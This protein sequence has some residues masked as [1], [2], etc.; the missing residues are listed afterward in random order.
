MSWQTWA[1]S[2]GVS[3]VVVA[4]CGSDDGKVRA[5][6]EDGGAA[7]EAEPASS[8]GAEAMASGGE[9]ASPGGAGEAAAEGGVA[10]GPAGEPE[11]GAAGEPEPGG[12]G[13]A[14]GAASDCVSPSE[15]GGHVYYS[16]LPT[17]AVAAEIR[18]I[19]S[20]GDQTFTTGQNP[21]LAPD[22]SHLAFQRGRRSLTDLSTADLWMRNMAT[23]DE[24]SLYTNTAEHQIGYAFTADSMALLYD[25][26]CGQYSMDLSGGSDATLF[27]DTCY[28][29][30]PALQPVVGGSLA[31]H[32][33][34]GIMLRDAAFQNKVALA[35]TLAGDYW[36]AWSPDG[37]HLALCHWTND[38]VCTY[39]RTGAD[40][41]ARTSL[42]ATTGWATLAFS[43]DGSKVA[44][45][46]L[47]DGAGGVHVF[48]AD[49]SGYLGVVCGTS[50]TVE[51]VG[52]ITA[53]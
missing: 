11:S 15:L 30:A 19:T 37:Q 45:G 43:A 23:G 34:S 31:Y 5:R 17:E 4:A 51:F 39:H 50:E 33:Q 14:G 8:G 53:D 7:G 40:G 42:G 20:A 2:L 26:S 28:D 36:P 3:V 38:N 32:N 21:K 13:G 29:D 24:E 16:T 10:G 35:N 18:V 52:S 41:G 9:G 49:G 44:T 47:K 12:T 6:A 22:G 1:L 27:Q 46:G 25:W 48:A